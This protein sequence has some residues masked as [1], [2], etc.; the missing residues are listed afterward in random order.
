MRA[1]VMLLAEAC[2]HCVAAQSSFQHSLLGGLSIGVSPFTCVQSCTC[3]AVVGQDSDL[4]RLRKGLDGWSAQVRAGKWCCRV[5]ATCYACTVTYRSVIKEPSNCVLRVYVF[6]K[7]RSSY[8]HAKV[9]PASLVIAFA[10]FM[11]TAMTQV[12]ECA[13]LVSFF[14]SVLTLGDVV[15]VQS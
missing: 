9:G 4:P 13:C 12:L 5:G 6:G 1:A 3:D 8:M 11:S 2:Q 10:C 15:C 14:A 7:S